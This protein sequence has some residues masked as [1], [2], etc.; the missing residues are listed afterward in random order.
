MKEHRD[1]G[2]DSKHR[3]ATVKENLAIFKAM[4]AG[5]VKKT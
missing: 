3:N 4:C 1:E 2:R 5:D